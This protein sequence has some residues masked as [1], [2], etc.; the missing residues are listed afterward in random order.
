MKYL[1]KLLSKYGANTTGPL[2]FKNCLRYKLSYLRDLG[3]LP[4]STGINVTLRNFDKF[5]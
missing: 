4:N 5:A 1:Y 2:Y 3:F